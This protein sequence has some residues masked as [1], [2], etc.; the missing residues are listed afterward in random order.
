M[1]RSVLLP[2]PRRTRDGDVF[3]R[4]DVQVNAGQRVGLH[5]VGEKH[6]FHPVE[7]DQGWDCS[8]DAWRSWMAACE[9]IFG[10]SLDPATDRRRS[11]LSVCVVSERMIWSP[12]CRPSRTSTM[13]SEP[14]PSLHLHARGLGAVGR[15]AEQADGAFLLPEGGSADDERVVDAFEFDGA[16]DAQV[17]PRAAGQRSVVEGHVHQH[18]ARLHGG[19]DPRRPGRRRCRCGYPRRRAG[20]AGCR[21]PGFP[22]S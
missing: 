10:G 9:S 19:V 12:A 18:G 16:L 3:S 13:L 1:D 21:A 6:F 22:E 5:L 11:L 17:G 20:P 4:L 2:Q 7:M 8:D 15:Q 14:R